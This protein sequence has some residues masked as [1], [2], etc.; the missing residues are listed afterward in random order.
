MPVSAARL[1][2]Q[3]EAG[4]GAVRLCDLDAR[5]TLTLVCEPCGRRGRYRV[6][7]L[8]VK[9]GPRAGLPDIRHVLANQGACRRSTSPPRLCTAVFRRVR[10]EPRPE[11]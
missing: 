7:N 3:L 2:R 10:S 5:G 4:C 9:Y 11:A 6:A 8:I 1:L